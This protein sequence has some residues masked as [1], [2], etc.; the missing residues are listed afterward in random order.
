[1]DSDAFLKQL[2]GRASLAGVEIS[3]A[4]A[5]HFETYYRLLARWN[6]RINLTALR[7]DPL[8][9]EATDR[10]FVEPLA[11]RPFLSRTSVWFDVGSG[12]G[13]PAIPLRLASPAARLSMVESKERK[14]AFLK[15]AIRVLGISQTFVEVQRIEALSTHQFIGSADLVTVRAV[16][17]DSELFTAVRALLKPR[18]RVALFGTT[19]SR[20]QVP[21]GFELTEDLQSASGR[22]LLVLALA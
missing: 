14:A 16:R 6:D 7:L 4:L 20:L 15:E 13:S 21:Q 12:G 1:M 2:A 5:K 11:A 17:L 22:Q 3:P 18:G 10:L 8:T 9:D 19:R